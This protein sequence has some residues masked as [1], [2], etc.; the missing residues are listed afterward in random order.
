MPK[1]PISI[2]DYPIHNP[3]D[4]SSGMDLIPEPERDLK[5][6]HPSGQKMI[7]FADYMKQAN[8]NSLKKTG[9]L[10]DAEKMEE[11]TAGSPSTASGGH[12]AKKTS[13]MQPQSG[14]RTIGSQ[15]SSDAAFDKDPRMGIDVQMFKDKL[16]DSD[17]EA[18]EAFAD[19]NGLEIDEVIQLAVMRDWDVRRLMDAVRDL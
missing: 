5:A 11:N 1:K 13:Y 14:K 6:A 3:D 19:K 9:F 18:I 10:K 12:H 15:G 17:V 16:S 7:S 8:Q 4:E 2:D